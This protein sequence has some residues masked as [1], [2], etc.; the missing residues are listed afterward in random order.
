MK[1]FKSSKMNTCVKIKVGCVTISLE[2]KKMQQKCNPVHTYMGNQSNSIRLS[3]LG[4]HCPNLNLEAGKQV[5]VVNPILK[6]GVLI[7]ASRF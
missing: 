7:F 2:E 5:N 6:K 3:I 1:T 4:V